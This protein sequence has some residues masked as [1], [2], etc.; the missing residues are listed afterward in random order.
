[1]AAC[2]L[3]QMQELCQQQ[4]LGCHELCPK[5]WCERVVYRVLHSSDC[6]PSCHPRMWMAAGEQVHQGRLQ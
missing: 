4:R 5:Q 1:M 6:A 2:E 3:G